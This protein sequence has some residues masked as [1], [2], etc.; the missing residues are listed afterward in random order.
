MD[1]GKLQKVINKGIGNTKL[2][3]QD[4]LIDKYADVISSYIRKERERDLLAMKT[5]SII[6]EV[7]ACSLK[8]GDKLTMIDKEGE[9][10]LASVWKINRKQIKY[11]YINYNKIKGEYEQRV[12]SIWIEDIY[13]Y[14]TE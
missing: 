1:V 11:D 7:I 12:N 9:M 3:Y 6:H 14:R 5:Q 4:E 8:R 13:D 10:I 2:R